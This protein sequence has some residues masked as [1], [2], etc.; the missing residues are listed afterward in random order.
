[1]LNAMLVRVDEDSG[2]ASEV[3]RIYREVD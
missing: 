2:Q 1:M 3:Q